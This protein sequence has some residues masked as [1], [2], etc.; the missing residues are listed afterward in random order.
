MSEALFLT[1]ARYHDDHPTALAMYCSDG[2]FTRGVEELVLHLGFDRLDT[3]T[4]PG[5]P[6]LLDAS[7]ATHADVEMIRRS[8]SFLI[9][10][11]HIKEIV[12]IAHDG[13]GYY[14]HRYPRKT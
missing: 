2:R 12:L 1:D 8:T 7:S 10:G 11:H 14:R 9:G 6:A 13:C 3:L 4:I 5:G